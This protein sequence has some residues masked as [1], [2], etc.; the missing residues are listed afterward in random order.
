MLITP[1]TSDALDT[2]PWVSAG[3]EDMPFLIR[4]MA[5]HNAQRRSAGVSAVRRATALAVVSYRSCE[6]SATNSGLIALR[7]FIPPVCY[8]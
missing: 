6:T 5:V 8:P 3:R 1:A 7:N 2:T 4:S